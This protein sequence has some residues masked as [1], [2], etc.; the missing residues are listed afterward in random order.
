MKIFNKIKVGL[1][2]GITFGI[3]DIIPMI[4]M[5]MTWDT[6]LSAFLMCVVGGFIISTSNLKFNHT[7]K[8]T[9]IFFLIAIPMMIIV[10]SGSPQELIPMVITNLVIGSLIGYFIGR[11]GEK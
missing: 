6:L 7:L 11:F 10:G 9:L 4:L 2:T 5:K 8:G 1:I 3:V